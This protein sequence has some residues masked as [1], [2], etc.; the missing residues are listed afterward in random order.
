MTD[1][2][3]VVWTVLFSAIYMVAGVK[4]MQ[5]LAT[6]I[7]ITQRRSIIHN[8]FMAIVPPINALAVSAPVGYLIYKIWKDGLLT[9]SSLERWSWVILRNQKFE[10]FKLFTKQSLTGDLLFKSKSD[11]ASFKEEIK[12]V[13]KI[14]G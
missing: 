7:Y 14:S 11:S 5:W 1:F 2:Q 6:V 12:S 8:L 10:Y 13:V 9:C 3:K 4:L